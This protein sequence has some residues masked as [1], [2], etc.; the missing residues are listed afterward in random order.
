MTDCE[1]HNSIN[2]EIINSFD[3]NPINREQHI[4]T[5]DTDNYDNVTTDK[6]L[7]NKFL[8]NVIKYLQTDDIIRKKT[9]EYRDDIKILKESK[10]DLEEYVIRYL[11]KEKEDYIDIRGKGKLIKKKTI[12][13]SV[14]K[15]DNIK[16]SIFEELT[17]RKLFET[18]D[19]KICLIENILE[20]IDKKRSVKEKTVLKRTFISK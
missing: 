3:D 12:T 10:N 17:Q 16:E 2:N 7:Q 14:I 5:S 6:K 1:K 9:N 13:K 11:D 15:L 19:E 8:E 18:N 20:K 4:E